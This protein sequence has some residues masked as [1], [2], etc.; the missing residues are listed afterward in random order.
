MRVRGK[1]VEMVQMEK[2]ETKSRGVFCVVN[3]CHFALLLL[4]LPLLH[5][6]LAST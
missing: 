4:L 6:C 5:A 1:K 2:M 3:H